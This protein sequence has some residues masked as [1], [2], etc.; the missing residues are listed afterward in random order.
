MNAELEQALRNVAARDFEE[1]GLLQDLAV[2]RAA[3]S[4]TAAHRASRQRTATPP[5]DACQVIN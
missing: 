5:P 3:R 4:G 2:T 1:E